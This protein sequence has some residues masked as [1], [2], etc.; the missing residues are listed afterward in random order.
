MV[1]DGD[2]VAVGFEVDEEAG[3]LR[4]GVGPFDGFRAF[5]EGLWGL[6]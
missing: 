4:G 1:R 3:V 5:D 6:C 2:A